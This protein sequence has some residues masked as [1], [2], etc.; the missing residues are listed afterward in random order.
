[1]EALIKRQIPG[2]TTCSEALQYNGNKVVIK[3]K[4]Y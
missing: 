3:L 4:L 2:K 1:M